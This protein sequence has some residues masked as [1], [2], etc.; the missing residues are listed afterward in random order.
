MKLDNIVL[1]THNQGKLIELQSMM[2]A[3]GL[4]SI[5]LKNAADYN[6][7]SPTESESTFTGNALLKARFV[8]RQ[9]GQATLA[10]D[11]GL[12]I[13]ALGGDPGVHSADW[14]GQTKDFGLAF[15]MI[16][17]RLEQLHLPLSRTHP[18]YPARFVCVLAFISNNGQ[19]DVFEGV[20][21]GHI[22]LPPRGTNGF[23]YDPIF[24]PDGKDKTFGEM[25]M[26]EKE[27]FSARGHAFG[28]F[29][30]YLKKSTQ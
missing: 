22:M 18:I 26:E 28:Q 15:D 2:H 27:K 10:D 7:C 8:A 14:A 23:G 12:C 6:L 5:K 11:S 1:A 4:S 30:A 24:Y 16:S 13:D 20:C 9:T 21:N 25:S 19:E 29:A 17:K 3:A